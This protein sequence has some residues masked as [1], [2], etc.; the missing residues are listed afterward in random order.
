MM[1]MLIGGIGGEIHSAAVH[2]SSGGREG[3]EVNR[4]HV[5][6]GESENGCVRV[7]FR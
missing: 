7:Q 3:N 4:Q 6:N 5:C 1:I 2:S